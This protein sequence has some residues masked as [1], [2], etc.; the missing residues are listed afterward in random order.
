M[1]E[2]IS[3]IRTWD[4]PTYFLL[5]PYQASHIFPVAGFSGGSTED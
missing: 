4:L 2:N 5:L 1:S 3:V